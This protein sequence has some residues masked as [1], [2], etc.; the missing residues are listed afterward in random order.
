MNESDVKDEGTEVSTQPEPATAQLPKRI[1]VAVVALILAAGALAL[2][3]WAA[4]RPTASEAAGP[5]AADD[6]TSTAAKQKACSAF[7]TV[8]R[9]VSLNTNASAPGGPNDV[10]GGLAVAANA[11]LALFGGGEYLMSQIDTAVPSEL[12]E[13]ATEFAETLMDIGAIAI[14]GVPTT[15][16]AQADRL[17]SAERLSSVIAEKCGG[18]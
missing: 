7:S 1:N 4:F 5:P 13:P 12:R 14:S 11:R 2:S 6:A 10:A 3:A 17:R 9:G 16:P 18:Q 15:E 8:R